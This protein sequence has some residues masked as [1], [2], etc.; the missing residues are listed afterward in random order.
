MTAI[1]ASSRNTPL[2]ADAP[3]PARR[4][5]E[6]APVSSE[7]YRGAISRLPT[8]ITVITAPGPDGPA[9]CTANAVLSLSLEPPS[10]LVSLATGSRT[11]AAVL[12]AGTFGVNVLTWADRA[13]AGQFA[14]GP[15][16]SR[17]RGVPWRPVRGVPVLDRTAVSAVCRIHQTVGLLD[18]TLVAGTVTWTRTGA[19]GATVLYRHRQHALEDER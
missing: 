12:A 7:D 10:L 2:T 4:P 13:L 11:L 9:G 14:T 19:T 6:H 16:D 1:P 5:A 8:G 3:L 17:F 18:H 15:G